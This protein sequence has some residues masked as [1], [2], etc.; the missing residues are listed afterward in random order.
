MLRNGRQGGPPPLRAGNRACARFAARL[1]A[2]IRGF[3]QLQSRTKLEFEAN[4]GPSKRIRSSLKQDFPDT[5][6]KH[7]L[8][9]F[10][11]RGTHPDPPI[12]SKPSVQAQPAVEARAEPHK[13]WCPN[14]SSDR[15]PALTLCGK[16]A[17]ETPE[18]LHFS[19]L[20]FDA[21]TL[22]RHLYIC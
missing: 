13:I 18:F 11:R 15:Q 20:R 1:L 22:S 8:H 16:F 10:S 12:P 9:F 14:H 6:A 17:S 7:P 21:S 5:R 19:A 2:I 4:S 3:A